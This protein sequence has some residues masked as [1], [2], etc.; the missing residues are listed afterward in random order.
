MATSI[1]SVSEFDYSMYLLSRIIVF[2]FL[3]LTFHLTSMSS[4]FNHVEACEFAIGP[5]RKSDIWKIHMLST[6]LKLEVYIYLYTHH[7][8]VIHTSV[9]GHRSLQFYG[10]C[11]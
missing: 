10:C 4:S 1:H 11:E 2:I 9:D 3:W 8:M 6:W 7:I 5:K